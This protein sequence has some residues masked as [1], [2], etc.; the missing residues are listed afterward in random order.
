MKK[1]LGF[2]VVL[3]FAIGFSADA[4]IIEEFEAAAGYGV[5]APWGDT[6][7]FTGA[8]GSVPLAGH[9]NY[10]RINRSGGS[11]QGESTFGI[12]TAVTPAHDLRLLGYMRM[13]PDK[14]WGGGSAGNWAWF[15]LDYA[16]GD[17]DSQWC[18][19]NGGSL[20][21]IQKF[22]E[23]MGAMID[24]TQYWSDVNAGAETAVTLCGKCGKTGD[25]NSAGQIDVFEVQD[26]TPA[27]MDWTL[28]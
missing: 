23:T 8:R 13:Q 11:A 5:Y 25:Q 18:A 17:H 1:V 19:D 24:W 10:A 9:G 2:V 12:G 27:V 14:T 26:I 3:T 21:I 6:N 22:D 15:E 7:T 16:W 4:V 20:V 28:Y